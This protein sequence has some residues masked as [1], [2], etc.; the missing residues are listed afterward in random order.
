MRNLALDTALRM[1]YGC[2]MTTTN[3]TNDEFL[4]GNLEAARQAAEEK[5][6]TLVESG[7]PETDP[8]VFGLDSIITAIEAFQS[9][10]GSN[11]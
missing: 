4:F 2:G 9:Q 3:F 7:T 11:D 6:M 1:A 8:V 5:A 10:F